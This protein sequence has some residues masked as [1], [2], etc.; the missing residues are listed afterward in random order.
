MI[1]CVQLSPDG[2]VCLS[3]GSDCT[4]KVWDLSTRKCVKSHGAEVGV[5][6]K[7]STFHRDTIT[8]MDVSFN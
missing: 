3:S 1:K 8:A 6:R 4:F 2:M 7:F 5:Q